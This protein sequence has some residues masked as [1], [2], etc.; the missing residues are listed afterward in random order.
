MSDDFFNDDEL[1]DD[2]DLF[3]MEGFVWQEATT[4]EWKKLYDA[5]DEL[6]SLAPWDIFCEIDIAEINLKDEEETYFCTITGMYDDRF[7]VG[8]YKGPSGL[9]S[10][11]NY[12]NAIEVPWYI[13]ENKKNCLECIWTSRNMLRKRDM[14]RLKS[15]EKTYRGKSAW[16][17]FRK[18]ETGFEPW[19][20]NQSEVRVLSEVLHQLA[21]AIKELIDAEMIN[22]ITDGD[23][24]KR[25]YDKETGTYKNEMLKPIDRIEA[26]AEGCVIT[27]ELLIRRLKKKP[28]N[29]MTLEFDLP[30]LPLPLNGMHEERPFHPRFCMLCNT[31]SMEIETQY[32]VD[33]HEDPRDIALSIII[34]YVE[35]KG[36]P[37]A[38]YVRDT[39]TFS[40]IGHLCK[41]IDVD[42]FLVP[43]LPMLDDFMQDIVDTML[44]K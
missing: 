17:H 25:S 3:D 9:V 27:D 11:S 21:C 37:A 20:L 29:G 23:R 36:R 39:E 5:A 16:P 13:A 22:D 19:Y 42:I 4:V 35:S 26:V 34:D 31:D 14:T 40:I 33:L 44:E 24:I 28:Q 7:G 43:A 41:S 18:Y 8:V 32:F 10:I 30:Y 38:I 15:C 2:E 1:Y 12:I 6:Y